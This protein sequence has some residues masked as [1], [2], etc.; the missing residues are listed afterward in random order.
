MTVEDLILHLMSVKNQSMQVMVEDSC[1]DLNDII[2]IYQEDEAE[3]E[4]VVI[5]STKD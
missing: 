1:S 4:S 3:Q 5:L 2:S